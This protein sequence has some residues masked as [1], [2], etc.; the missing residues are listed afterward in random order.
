MVHVERGNKQ[1]ERGGYAYL[2]SAAMEPL[3]AGQRS[4]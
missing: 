3:L 4:A 1:G 2:H